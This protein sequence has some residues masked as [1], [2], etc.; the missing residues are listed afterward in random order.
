VYPDEVVG[1]ALGIRRQDPE[2]SILAS[3]MVVAIMTVGGLHFPDPY[4][5][6][7][8]NQCA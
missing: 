6:G 7:E 8:F 2:A 1:E 4:S 5:G 3:P